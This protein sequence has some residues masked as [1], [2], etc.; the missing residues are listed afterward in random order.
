M[1]H[2]PSTIDMPATSEARQT[3]DFMVVLRKI[4]SGPELARENVVSGDLNAILEQLWLDKW[5]RCGRL[6]VPIESLSFRII[7]ECENGTGKCCTRFLFQA[8]DGQGRVAECKLEL[9]VFQDVAGRA[10]RR[11]VATKL[12]QTGDTYFYE[13]H[14]NERPAPAIADTDQ[15]SLFKVTIKNQPLK[16][17][18]MKVGVLLERSSPVGPVVEGVMPVFYTADA[19]RQSEHFARKGAANNPPTETGAVLAGWPCSCPESG[20]FYVVISDALE[21]WDAER[22]EFSLTYSSKTWNS[23]QTVIKAR[24]LRG[25]NSAYRILGQSHGHNFTPAGDGVNCTNCRETTECKRTSV[26]A[27]LDD[28]IWSRAVFDRQPWHVC[29]IFGMNARGENVSAL[30]SV[31]D[32]RFVPRGFH[33]IDGFDPGLSA[34]G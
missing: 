9:E 5:L 14:A 15:G 3:T 31:R 23:I 20:E 30:Y 13:V 16:H 2:V 10:A 29:Q 22:S 11:L 26:F 6:D 25:G 17:L 33:L 4:F 24:Q 32:N 34:P 28:R 12:L 19:L 27:S 1:I 7:P 21:V 8:I 18:S